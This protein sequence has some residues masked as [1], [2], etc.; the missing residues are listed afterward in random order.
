MTRFV[1]CRNCGR[2]P[3]E[4]FMYGEIP[5]VPDSLTEADARDL[6]RVYMR[7]NPT[8]EAPEGWFHSAGCRRWSYL[9]RDRTTGEWR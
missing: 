5:Q 9:R 3:V 8:G 1:P 6:D 4:E 7:S 2:R